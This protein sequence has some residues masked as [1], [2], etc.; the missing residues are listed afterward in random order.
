MK[1]TRNPDRANSTEP[2]IY[3]DVSATSTGVALNFQNARAAQESTGW[4]KAGFDSH[5]PTNYL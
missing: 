1:P 3:N 2:S 5:S 4:L